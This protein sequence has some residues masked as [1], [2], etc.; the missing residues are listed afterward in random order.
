MSRPRPRHRVTTPGFRLHRANVRGHV[1]V[2]IHPDSGE[3]GTHGQ[4]ETLNAHGM[5][6][7][8]PDP[9]PRDAPCDFR[10]NLIHEKRTLEVPG[11]VVYANPDGMAVQFDHLEPRTLALLA[12][13]TSHMLNR[14]A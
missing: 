10:L 4:V 12:G 1:T 8:C 14:R 5:F 2:D 9:L 13:F 7:H 6:V 3:P 11:W